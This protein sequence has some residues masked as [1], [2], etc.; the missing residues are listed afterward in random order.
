[1]AEPASLFIV[2]GAIQSLA[3]LFQELVRIRI[4]LLV[5]SI[6]YLLCF[7]FTAEALPWQVITGILMASLANLA[8]L[9]MLMIRRSARMF[10]PDQLALF[11]MFG[12]VQRV[13]FVHSCIMARSTR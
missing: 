2:A 10:P 1:M 6:V 7:V 4:L 3:L 11:S 12:G 9:I 8:G 5:G 13:N